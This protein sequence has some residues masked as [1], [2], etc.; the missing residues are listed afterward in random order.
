MLSGSLFEGA[1][2]PP[3]VV[4]K[5]I[6]HWACHTS[7]QNVLQW[8]KVENLYIKTLY[9]NLRAICTAALHNK[10]QKMGGNKRKIQVCVIV[11]YN[12]Y[13]MYDNIDEIEPCNVI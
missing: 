12:L 2:H 13:R 6:Y 4:L 5:L 10:Y 11:L 1:P 3:A 9:T 7:V 8:V